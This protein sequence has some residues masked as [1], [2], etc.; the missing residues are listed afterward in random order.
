MESDLDSSAVRYA[1]I[2]AMRSEGPPE[3]FVIPYRTEQSLRLVI[4]DFA[5]LARAFLPATKRS[6]LANPSSV[7]PPSTAAPQVWDVVATTGASGN[8]AT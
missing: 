6:K 4:A 2:E 1:V 8:P 7:Q 3:F 5:S